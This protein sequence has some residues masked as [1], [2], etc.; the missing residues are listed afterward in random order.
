[1]SYPPILQKFLQNDG[2]GPLIKAE[3]LPEIPEP[4]GGAFDTII[5]LTTSQ[6][7]KALKT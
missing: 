2:A 7:F 3:L 5:T 6:T 4:G 1:M